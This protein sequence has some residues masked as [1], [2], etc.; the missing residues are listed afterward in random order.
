MSTET[1]KAIGFYK[2]GDVKE[3]MD[4]EVVE[5]ERPKPAGRDLLVQVKAVSVNP[6]DLR[7]RDAKKDG[8]ESFTVVGRDAAGIVAE[9][10]EDC[11]LFKPGDEVWYAG[12]NNRPGSQSEFQL[13]DERIVGKKPKSLDFAQ[14]A[15]LP[16][17][18][19]TA[20][21][22]MFDRLG[23][24]ENAADNKGKSILIIG[25]AGGVGSIAT[26]I[27]KQ[28]GLTVIGTA[29]RPQTVEWAKEHGADY[30][31]NHREPL[32]PQLKE[33]GFDNV[34]YIFCLSATDEHM[35]DMTTVIAPQGKIC[36]ILPA[37]KPL[38]PR[39]FA[40][41]VT[42]AYELMYTRSV[43]QTEDMIR[44][45]ELLD[46][47][48]DDVD[49]GELETTKTEHFT[50]ISPSALKEAYSNLLTGRTIGKI[51]VEGPFEE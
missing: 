2:P 50:P 26:Q 11:S 7:T 41:S 29:S 12:T 19:L 46:R 22:A 13:V 31:I 16:L 36:S 38:D 3:P 35:T 21:E 8:D 6:T 42:F 33:L 18:S 24:S 27:A 49:A 17:T 25:A 5:M 51:V 37:F 39:L 1:M 9:V 43:F 48:A 44:Q 23:I 32:E 20:Y 14:A 4:L 10:G 45:H 15:A 34:P 30:T 47:L 28:A 40:K